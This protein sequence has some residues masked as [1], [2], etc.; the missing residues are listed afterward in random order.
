MPPTSNEFLAYTPDELWMEF[1]EDYYEAKPSEIDI[2]EDGED[3]VF[4]TGD[5]EYD[6]LE[7]RISE[8]TISDDEIQEVLRGWG[9]ERSKDGEMTEQDPVVE[10]PIPD[11]G[12]GFEDNY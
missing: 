11:I 3:V 6:E 8:G 5:P 12:S 1:Y 2:D 10:Q 9:G 7:K 4:V